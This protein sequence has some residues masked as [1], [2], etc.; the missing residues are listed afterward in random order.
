MEDQNYNG[1]I[2]CDKDGREN[3]R[4]LIHNVSE[5]PQEGPK[6]NDK[7]KASLP[8]LFY[9]EYINKYV[10]PK[11]LLVS[12][13][14]YLNASDG[15]AEKSQATRDEEERREVCITNESLINKIA[16]SLETVETDEKKIE[17]LT[18]EE[19]QIGGQAELDQLKHAK[20]EEQEELARIKKCKDE[21]EDENKRE[22]EQDETEKNKEKTKEETLFDNAKTVK[23]LEEATVDEKRNEAEDD[24]EK[25]IQRE[26]YNE[27]LLLLE[28]NIIP[29]FEPFDCPI[30]FVLYK[31]QEGLILRNCLHTF[32]KQCIA[33]TVLHSEEAD[34]KCPYKNDDYSCEET[35]QQ[36]EIKSV[37]KPADF[38]KYLKRSVTQ[39]ES[40]AGKY[41]FH[42]KT[43]D[44]PSWCYCEPGVDHFLC[45]VCKE[46]N[47]FLCQKIHTG[48]GCVDNSLYGTISNGPDALIE[49]LLQSQDA[50]LCPTCSAVIMK[51][52]G[53]DGLTCPACK[54]DICWI[55]RGPRWG[56]KGRG[57]KT[58]GC[59]CEPYARCHPRCYNCH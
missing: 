2:E 59:K 53:C 20:D 10:F 13:P 52:D 38:Q 1:E 28:S 17:R 19:V 39:A 29:N 45:P 50:L 25:Y 43:P 15:D 27:M 33:N 3:N 8:N 36:C 5:G 44:C 24:E 54:T 12:T 31:S 55:T 32:C 7:D 4:Q 58:G 48:R 23:N 49:K 22:T 16:E 6:E 57:D 26:R 18:E 56:P 14:Q 42:C 21:N 37:L 34:I 11:P 40:K 51:I 46:D 47:C 41:A 35:I 9:E 30:C